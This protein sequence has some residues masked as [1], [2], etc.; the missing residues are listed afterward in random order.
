MQGQISHILCVIILWIT[1]SASFAQNLIPN[2]SFEDNIK[3]DLSAWT[4]PTGRHYHY[5][6]DSLP[7]AFDGKSTT[8]LCFHRDTVEASEYLTV[9]LNQQLQKGKVYDASMMVS[10]YT[11]EQPYEH[12]SGQ[13]S[14]RQL[15]WIFTKEEPEFKSRNILFDPDVV[16]F[17]P[18]MTKYPQ[19]TESAGKYKATGEEQYITMGH[20][21][22]EQ[23]TSEAFQVRYRLDSLEKEKDKMIDSLDQYYE[24]KYEDLKVKYDKL[25][26]QKKKSAKQAAADIAKEMNR[27]SRLRR[28]LKADMGNYFSNKHYKILMEDIQNDFVARFCFDNIKLNQS[29]AKPLSIEDLETNSISIDRNYTL[30]NVYFDTNSWKIRDSSSFEFLRSL[31]KYLKNHSDFD[32]LVSGHTDNEGTDE[33]NEALSRNRSKSIKE[34]LVSKGVAS[35]RISCEGFGKRFPASQNTILKGRQLNRR[36]EIVFYKA[37]PG[38]N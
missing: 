8:C 26:A 14:V 7:S 20:F 33:H 22:S 16:F 29:P 15:G 5:Y 2:H 3:R 38:I 1:A 11:N 32:I 9:K 24:I 17:L 35:D 30:S 6:T 36:V 18:D 12:F 28:R 27:I 4:H 34:Y 13:E 19:W 10:L 23:D 37:S 31:A 25:N 21:Y